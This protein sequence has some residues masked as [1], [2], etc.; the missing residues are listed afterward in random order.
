MPNGLTAAVTLLLTSSNAAFGQTFTKIGDGLCL[1]PLQDFSLTDSADTRR[2]RYDTINSRFTHDFNTVQ[3]CQAACAALQPNCKGFDW[4]DED[5]K[6]VNHEPQHAHDRD[7]Q[8]TVYGPGMQG[9]PS[10]MFYGETDGIPC[11][12]V[13]DHTPSCDGTAESPCWEI[14]GVH[15][16]QLD[17]NGPTTVKADGTPGLSYFPGSITGSEGGSNYVG[18]APSCYVREPW[19][20]NP[21]GPPAGA[22]CDCFGMYEL[23]KGD[24]KTS[25][26]RKWRTISPQS[27]D[28]AAC[29]TVQ[30]ADCVAGDGVR[31]SSTKMGSLFGQ[32][33]DCVG[34]WSVCTADCEKKEDRT[35]TSVHPQQQGGQGCPRVT[36][37]P[38]PSSVV[39]Q[40]T[41][42]SSNSRPLAA[43]CGLLAITL[44][45]GCLSSF[46]I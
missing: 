19:C 33:G 28:G 46:W 11:P 21:A 25:A 40:N 3:E 18:E 27:G 16:P 4:R 42:K 31:S 26:A 45:H 1:G 37:C 34:D 44:S 36:D 32:C 38:C 22:D 9:P 17:A 6:T 7:H 5:T 8:C 14:G 2:Y 10:G 20:E 23:C 41:P 12:S 24:C 35:L 39:P 29:P 30:I 15:V 13:L 43:V